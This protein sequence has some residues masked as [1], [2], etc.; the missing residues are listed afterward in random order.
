MFKSKFHP[1]FVSAEIVLPL[2][3]VIL[4]FASSC[5]KNDWPSNGH[6]P[7]TFTA[8]VIDKWMTMQIRLMRNATGI[9]NQAFS[10]HYAYAGI[11]ALESVAPGLPA[12]SASYRKWNGLSGLPAAQHGV[13]YYYPANVNA[14]MARINKLLF[15]NASASDKQ[16]I[17]SLETALQQSFAAKE[18]ASLLTKSADFGKAVAQA[19]FNWGEEDGYKNANDPYT[20]P[21]G[22]GLWK[23][24]PPAFAAAATPYWGN[25][26]PTV[27]N[28]LQGSHPAAPP[29]YSTEVGSPFHNMVKQVYDISL[30]LTDDQKNSAVFWRDVPGVSSPGHWLS[31]LQQVIRQTNTKLDKAIVAYALSGAAVN[32][33]LISCWKAKYQYNLLRPITYIRETMGQSAWNTYIGTPAHPEYPSAHSSLSAA[34]AAVLE[35][36]FGNNAAITDRTYEY[37][38]Y[39]AR[40]Y[41]TFNAIAQD[42]GWSRVY[43][44][45]HYM[46]SVNA[47]L[48]QGKKVAMNILPKIPNAQ[49]FDF[50]K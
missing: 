17:D 12:Q 30:T 16:A 36:V 1:A 25:N 39:P 9:P 21:V 48:T 26:R 49:I 31:I 45:I 35:Q 8:D 22:V 34:A 5:K 14:A 28:S 44:G 32:D 27:V 10:R 43:A 38:G 47:G 3:L 33:A 46:P 11:A 4:F 7:S 6:P 2:T 29:A 41:A 19:V 15:P 37:L 40:T 24:T 23:P 50:V 42:A 20:P 13:R 18:P